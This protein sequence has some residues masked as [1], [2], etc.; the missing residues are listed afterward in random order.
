[1]TYAHMG[2]RMA[3]VIGTAFAISAMAQVPATPK[4]KFQTNLGNFTLELYP[5]KAPKTV[6]NFLQYVKDK[7]SNALTNHLQRP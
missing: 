6:E 7:Q 2:R 4:V 1:M 5:D 3:L